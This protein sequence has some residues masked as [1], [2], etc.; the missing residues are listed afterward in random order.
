[1][2]IALLKIPD[3]PLLILGHLVPWKWRTTVVVLSIAFGVSL[4][5]CQPVI[6]FTTGVKSMIRLSFILLFA[7]LFFCE[8]IGE[9]LEA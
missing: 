4:G 1:M 6:Q 7:R 5:H 9:L 8:A 3:V 2:K